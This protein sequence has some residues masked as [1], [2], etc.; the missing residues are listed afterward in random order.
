MD[1]PSFTDLPGCSAPRTR[2]SRWHSS[3]ESL[4]SLLQ[5]RVSTPCQGALTAVTPTAAAGGTGHACFKAEG[6]LLAHSDP[7]ENWK[8]ADRFT[9]GLC[10]L[11]LPGAEGTEL[12]WRG[13]PQLGRS[14]P[15]PAAVSSPGESLQQLICPRPSGARGETHRAALS[16]S[17]ERPHQAPGR[18][19]C[20]AQLRDSTAP[21]QVGDRTASAQVGTGQPLYRWGQDRLCTGG[22]Q[23][24]PWTGGDR[25]TPGQVRVR[26]TPGQVRVRTA[27]AQVR[28]RTASGQVGTNPLRGESRPHQPPASTSPGPGIILRLRGAGRLVSRCGCWNLAGTGPRA[29][30]LGRG[31]LCPL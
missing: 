29:R 24:H 1:P 12:Q 31:P 6:R 14:H 5:R 21:G 30:L 27:S 4:G 17:S 15:R 9:R 3:P 18:G 8:S 26:T 7:E 16:L 2:K 20:W 19:S 23:D 22:G 28:V 25:T 11:A 13:G 10:G